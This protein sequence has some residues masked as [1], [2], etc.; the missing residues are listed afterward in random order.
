MSSPA[1]RTARNLRTTLAAVALGITAGCGGP[2]AS[3]A[4][5]EAAGTATT[6]ATAEPT[7]VAATVAAL[8]GDADATAAFGNDDVERGYDEVVDLATREAF[9]P[10]FFAWTGRNTPDLLAPVYDRLTPESAATL[11][12]DAARC[13]EM[14]SQSCVDVWGLAYF[15]FGADHQRFTFL[16]DGSFVTDQAVT[17]PQVWVDTNDRSRVNFRFDHKAE[18]GMLMNGKPVVIELPRTLT[19]A[20]VRAPEGAGR[21]WLL[22]GYQVTVGSQSIK[23]PVTG[24]AVAVPTAPATS[25]AN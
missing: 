1:S 10:D 17:S 8:P 4:A 12:E 3:G 19:Y 20:L 21:A 14:D 25:P 24:E 5:P 15:D 16:P 6:S 23:D 9:N 2:A 11:R 13:L 22:D 18:I 7:V